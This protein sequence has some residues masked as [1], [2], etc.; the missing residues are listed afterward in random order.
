MTLQSWSKKLSHK[1]EFQYYGKYDWYNYYQCTVCKINNKRWRPSAIIWK[2]ATSTDHV[3][4]MIGYVAYKERE[5]NGK[6]TRCRCRIP[7]KIK[8]DDIKYWPI[9]C[10]YT[11]DEFTIKDI[12]E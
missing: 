7:K 4:E 10:P 11:E 1:V 3:T 6:I 5:R 12:I 9:Y 2:D 8:D